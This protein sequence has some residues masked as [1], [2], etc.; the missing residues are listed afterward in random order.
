MIQNILTQP[1]QGPQ[2]AFNNANRGLGAGIAGVASTYKGPSIKV[3][4]E[5]QK[6]HEWEFVYDPQKEAAE[7]AKAAGALPPG[8]TPG[9]QASPAQ[10]PGFGAMSGSSTKK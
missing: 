9:G 1:R 4:E 8:T 2:G 5:R 10:N 7:K 6:Y 3:Y